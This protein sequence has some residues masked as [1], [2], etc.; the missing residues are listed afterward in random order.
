TELFRSPEVPRGNITVDAHDGVVTLRGH[1]DSE[2]S[3]ED[4]A[5]I[6]GNVAGVRHVRNDLELSPAAP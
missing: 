5:Q 4:L 3:R 6:V 1:V 2:G